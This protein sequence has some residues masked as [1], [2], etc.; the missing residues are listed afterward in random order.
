MDQRLQ[1]LRREDPEA[2][3]LAAVRAGLVF[4]Y[5]HPLGPPSILELQCLSCDAK[6]VWSDCQ[7]CVAC[8]DDEDLLYGPQTVA[9]AVDGR[10]V[11]TNVDGWCKVCRG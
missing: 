11:K 4:N 2:W 3:L 1:A 5:E 10:I 7:H 6:R 9:M 8:C